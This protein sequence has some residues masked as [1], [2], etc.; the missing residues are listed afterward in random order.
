MFKESWKFDQSEDVAAITTKKVLYE[1][2]PILSVIHYDDDHSWAFTCGTTN[3]PSDGV[4]VSMKCIID[5]DLTLCELADLE[6]GWGA[7][8][9]SLD[10]DWK[11]YKLEN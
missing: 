2:F 4:V 11:I 1:H 10:D 8:R 6:P 5:F 3:N 9:E 7:W